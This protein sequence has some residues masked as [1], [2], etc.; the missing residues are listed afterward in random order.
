MIDFPPR[1][2]LMMLSIVGVAWLVVG[3]F[4]AIVGLSVARAPR[5]AASIADFH[6]A[7]VTAGYSL[8]TALLLLGV[9]WL[10]IRPDQRALVRAAVLWMGAT[11]LLLGTRKVSGW[12]LMVAAVVALGI[13]VDV[14]R[15]LGVTA[16]L[17]WRTRRRATGG[18]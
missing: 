12:P 2:R 8:G 13:A 14:I 3:A 4:A 10:V 17:L 6:A 1:L 16:Q 11:A 7:A 18:V 9:S 5:P 15:R